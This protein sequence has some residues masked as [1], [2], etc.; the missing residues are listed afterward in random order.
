MLVEV[1]KFT[2]P[3]NIVILEMEEHSKVPLILGIPFL[4]I[5][6]VVIRVKQKQ[7]NLRFGTE[8]MI[9]HIDSTMKHSNSKDDTCFNIDVIDKIFEEY[10]DAFHDEGSE[11]LHSIEGTIL[12]EKLFVEFNEF[13][14]MTADENSESESD[15]KEPPFEKITFNTN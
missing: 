10:F 3:I 13:M 12:E 2:F 15:T 5:V 14:T 6:D 4:Y 7:L 11:I 1:S 8:R 9:F